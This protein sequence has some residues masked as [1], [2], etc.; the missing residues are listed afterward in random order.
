M[1]EEGSVPGTCGREGRDE[2]MLPR[3]RT[4]PVLMGARRNLIRHARFKD[5]LD[6]DSVR[7]GK[8]ISVINK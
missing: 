2:T 6:R 7:K 1:D 4:W 3:R 5:R 8:I